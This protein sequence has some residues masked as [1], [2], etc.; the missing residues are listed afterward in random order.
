LFP[1]KFTPE[2]CFPKIIFSRKIGAGSR[3][4]HLKDCFEFREKL[5]DP[6]FMRVALLLVLG[7]FGCSSAFS[8]EVIDLDTYR[9]QK[10]HQE[11]PVDPD[12]FI[13]EFGQRPKGGGNQKVY[14]EAYWFAITPLENG[15]FGNRSANAHEWASGVAKYYKTP[16]QF[17]EWRKRYW[18]AL[19]FALKKG[20][21]QAS[22]SQWAKHIADNS[23]S[24]KLDEIIAKHFGWSR[25]FYQFGEKYRKLNQPSHTPTHPE[26]ASD[27]SRGQVVELRPASKSSAVAPESTALMSMAKDPTSAHVA[28]CVKNMINIIFDSLGLMIH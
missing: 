14:E 13:S 17:D 18:K 1:E 22:A 7:I 21:D 24:K 8:G 20:D 5:D 11:E 19:E 23:T 12:D 25:P 4:I 15:G 2:K 28:Q 27:Q 9:K 10:S 3:S 26:G 16:Q 6:K